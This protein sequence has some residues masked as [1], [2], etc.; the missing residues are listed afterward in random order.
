MSEKTVRGAEQHHMRPLALDYAE[1][2]RVE[3]RP[4]HYDEDQG[5]WVIEDE[6][7]EVPLIG[8]REVTLDETVTKVQ[9]EATD[10]A[11][12]RRGASNDAGH[13]TSQAIERAGLGETKTGVPSDPTDPPRP[14]RVASRRRGPEE[15]LTFVD[16]EGTDESQPRRSRR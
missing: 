16:D 2:V 11:Q 14:R 10:Q 3:K 7:G 15:T 13:D 8:A 1:R 12:P 6:S 9:A 4:G 5:L